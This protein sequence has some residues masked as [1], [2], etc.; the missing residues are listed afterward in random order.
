M[1]IFNMS[2][3]LLAETRPKGFVAIEPVRVNADDHPV[4]HFVLNYQFI[5]SRV[6]GEVFKCISGSGIGLQ[7]SAVIANLLFHTLQTS[8]R[9]STIW[10]I[11]SRS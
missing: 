2:G 8:A 7:H 9:A 6:L 3:A 11:C 10:K 5:S 1:I 4:L